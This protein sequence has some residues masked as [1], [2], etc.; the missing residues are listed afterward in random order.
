MSP[1]TNELK[2]IK[3]DK[4][5]LKQTSKEKMKENEV[6]TWRGWGARKKLLE[7]TR[8]VNGLAVND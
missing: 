3:A 5:Q 7:E 4:Q 6:V 2:T 8:R 1:R